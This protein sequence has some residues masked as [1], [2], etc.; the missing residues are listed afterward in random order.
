MGHFQ[1]WINKVQMDLLHTFR[2][3][4]KADGSKVIRQNA[5]MIKE[6]HTE[7]SAKM[8][9]RE[10]MRA[11]LKLQSAGIEDITEEMQERINVVLMAEQGARQQV[12][13]L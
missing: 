4:D 3:A 7:I 6:M 5:K 8:K 12:A 10:Y 2:Q 9:L 11:Y 1:D 13:T